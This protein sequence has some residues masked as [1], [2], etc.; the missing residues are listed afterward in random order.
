M[1]MWWHRKGDMR[2]LGFSKSAKAL[3]LE[4]LTGEFSFWR[5]AYIVGRYIHRNIDNFERTQ[6]SIG[7]FC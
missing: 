4:T 5:V 7:V 2:I 1:F 3:Q 6:V